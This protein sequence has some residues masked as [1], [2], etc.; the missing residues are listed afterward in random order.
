MYTFSNGMLISSQLATADTTNQPTT[1][2]LQGNKFADKM[3][4]STLA[5]AIAWYESPEK[6]IFCVDFLDAFSAK[7]IDGFWQEELESHFE[8][9][10]V[11]AI[12]TELA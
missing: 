4:N 10:I 3:K 7:Q 12:K 5:D 2:M 9:L 6:T 1:I 8:D 11:G